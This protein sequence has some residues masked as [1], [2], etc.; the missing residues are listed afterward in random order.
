MPEREGVRENVDPRS[1]EAVRRVWGYDT[2]RPLQAASIE[3]GVSGRDCLTV[4]PTGGG[5]SLCYQVPPLVTGKATVVISPLIALM[6]DQVRGLKLNGYEAGALHSA[7]DREDAR[8]IESRLLRGDLLLVLAA[9]ER[10]LTSGFCALLAKLHDAGR[11]GAIAI[12]EAHCISQWGHDFRPE[13]R[14]LVELRRIAPGVGMQAFTATATPRVREDIVRQLGLEDAEVLVGSFDRPNLTYRV[15]H[16][17]DAA[18]Q[19]I[20]AVRAMHD[21]GEGGGAIVYCLSRADTE[22]LAESL[23]VAGLDARAYHAGMDKG[24]RHD[25]E[26]AFTN[27]SLD[28][29]VATVAFGMGID[30]S[31]VRLVVHACLPKSVEAYQQEAGRAG[32]DGLGAECL[33]LAAPSDGSR[34]ERLILRSASESGADPS[35]QLAL[36]DDVRRFAGALLCRHRA[37][38]EYFGQSYEPENCGACDVCLGETREESDSAVLAQKLMSGVA[39]TGQ[40]YGAGYVADVLRGAVT[41]DVVARGHNALSVFGLLAKRSRKEIMVLLDQLV[42]L[43]ALRADEHRVLRFGARGVAVMKGEAGVRLAAPLGVRGAGSER[44][45]ERGR[46]VDAAPLTIEEREVFERLRGL[47]KRIAEESEVPPYVVFSDATLREMARLLPRSP[48]Q[49]LEV[50]GVGRRKL[51]MFGEAFLEEIVAGAGG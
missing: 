13:Y 16:R 31:N 39:R 8:E 7:L 14:R 30:R 40:R 38:C 1:M 27:E 11:L 21:R 2:L 34:W 18:E 48:E 3:A 6:R 32:R 9:P 24:P 51:E 4:L 50:K 33:L 44:R 46:V 43:G 20:E 35:A 47:R 10:A 49:L 29:V 22:R 5:K 42:A 19:T 17:R 12:D 45:R 15:R 25:V 26:R 36:L 28:V 41:D 37:L 23:R